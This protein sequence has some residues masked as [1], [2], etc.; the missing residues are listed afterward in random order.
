[1]EGP[2]DAKEKWGSPLILSLL[3]RRRGKL[4]PRKRSQERKRKG[5]E[6]LP[7]GAR[8]G[9][10]SITVTPQRKKKKF[11]LKLGEKRGGKE[12]F[13]TEI[14]IREKNKIHSRT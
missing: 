5:G 11:F 14:R 3:S 10:C 2:N 6:R 9:T 1:M 12:V 7:R 8:E 4:K 13:L